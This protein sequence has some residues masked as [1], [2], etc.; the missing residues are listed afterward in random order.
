MLELEAKKA[1]L[2]REILFE[3]EEEVVQKL[4]RF[5][6]EMKMQPAIKPP[7]RARLERQRGMV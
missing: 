5:F 1:E 3:T 6:R 7:S 2:A 4:T